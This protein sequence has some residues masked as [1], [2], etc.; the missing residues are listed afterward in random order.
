MNELMN[1][2]LSTVTNAIN[3]TVTYICWEREYVVSID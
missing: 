1:E 3:W 2:S